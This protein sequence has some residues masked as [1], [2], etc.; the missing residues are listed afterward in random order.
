MAHLH[1][2]TVIAL[3]SATLPLIQCT[4]LTKVDWTLIPTASAGSGGVQNSAGET[5]AAG[6]PTTSDAGSSSGGAAGENTG[7]ASVAS[8]GASGTSG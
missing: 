6:T 5:S 1:Q 8:I 3:L 2:F 7:A 4:E